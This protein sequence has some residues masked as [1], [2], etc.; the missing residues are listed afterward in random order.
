MKFT[1][2]FDKVMGKF[3]IVMGFGGFLILLILITIYAF[4]HEI[5]TDVSN[6]NTNIKLT[7]KIILNTTN[8]YSLMCIKGYA[9]IKDNNGNF[10]QF[11]IK[12]DNMSKSSTPAKCYEIN[13]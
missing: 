2:I 8:D 7:N 4:I 1:D 3:D 11:F 9:F 10:T 13:K 6:E 12:T 5:S